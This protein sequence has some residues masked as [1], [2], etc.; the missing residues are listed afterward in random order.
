[1]FY[2]HS[3]KCTFVCKAVSSGVFWAM[4][5]HVTLFTSGVNYF[6]TLA[7]VLLCLLTNFPTATMSLSYSNGHPN[8]SEALKHERLPWELTPMVKG[9]VFIAVDN[10]LLQINPDGS[11]SGTA[12]RSSRY[13]MLQTKSHYIKEK[14]V[15]AIQGTETQLYLCMDGSG[16]LYASPENQFTESEC[17][18]KFNQQ[19]IQSNDS[20][21]NKTVFRLSRLRH[22]KKPFYVG[23]NCD[24]QPIVAKDCRQRR[25]LRKYLLF[26]MGDFN[27]AQNSGSCVGTPKPKCIRTYLKFCK[28]VVRNFF[29]SSVR[30]L[31]Q[32]RKRNCFQRIRKDR[33]NRDKIAGRCNLKPVRHRRRTRRRHRRHPT[34]ILL[35][36]FLGHSLPVSSQH[37]LTTNTKVL[38]PAALRTPNAKLLHACDRSNS[39]IT[40][41]RSAVQSRVRSK[42]RKYT[43]FSRADVHWICSTLTY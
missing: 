21:N 18:F 2:I 13:A 40:S 31:K 8:A 7:I 27:P 23:L 39:D 24:G 20:A 12:C 5:T 43:F 6:T 9:T 25:Q 32:F 1:M 41:R 33:R 26:N 37:G 29:R 14:K 36:G 17:S 22:H 3:V 16:K 28:K 42:R 19:W 15:I 11:I 30:E 35:K 4:T 34:W 10:K 38:I